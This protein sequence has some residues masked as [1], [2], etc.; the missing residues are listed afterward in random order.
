LQKTIGSNIF[1]SSYG[2]IIPGANDQNQQ[3]EQSLPTQ[4]KSK[5]QQDKERESKFKF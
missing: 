3:E 4:Q 1:G 2:Y 5:E